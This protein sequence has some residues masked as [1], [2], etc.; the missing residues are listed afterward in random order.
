MVIDAAVIAR[1]CD[2]AAS[3]DAQATIA[4]LQ[5]E[6]ATEVRRQRPLCVSSG[7]CCGFEAHGHRLYLTG[8]ET[9]WTWARLERR[10]SV[11]EVEAAMAGGSCPFLARGCSIHGVR[12]PGC[13][14]YFCDRDPAGWQSALAERCHHEIR[15]LHERLDVPYRYAEW[16]SLL[17]GFA[18]G[19]TAS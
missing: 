5:D 18:A 19:E 1:W 3:I 11:R 7:K 14:I 10:P 12:P 8:L 17:A 6:I 9:A 16:R 13:R 15:S 2:A 4:R